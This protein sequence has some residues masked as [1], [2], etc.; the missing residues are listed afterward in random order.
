MFASGNCHIA[1]LSAVSDTGSFNRYVKPKRPIST[2]ASELT[3]ITFEDDQMFLRGVPVESVSLQTC[4]LAFWEFLGED[5]C[6]LVAHNCNSFDS[7]VLYRSVRSAG[8][9]IQLSAHVAGFLDTLPLFRTRYPDMEN[10]KLPTLVNHFMNIPYEE[11]NAVDDAGNLR[12]LLHHCAFDWE[13]KQP[14]TFSL[15]YVQQIVAFLD[16]RKENMAALWPLVDAK[17]LTEHTAEK[18]AGSGL[19]EEHLRLAFNEQQREGIASLFSEPAPDGKPRVTDQQ[20]IINS[21]FNY[22]D[23]GQLRA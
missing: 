10:H 8:G 13:N 9:L 3:G 5:L 16:Q 7:R 21:V 23:M 22:Y 15:H 18:I 11:H 12:Q 17:V 20:H 14:H 6:V 4:L 2:E 1:Q 19:K